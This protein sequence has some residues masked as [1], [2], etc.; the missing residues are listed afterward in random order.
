ML[1]Q[2]RLGA[3]GAGLLRSL[4]LTFCEDE[5]MLGNEAAKGVLGQVEDVAGG[6]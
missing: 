5:I 2:T 4:L 3:G 6:C 1:V